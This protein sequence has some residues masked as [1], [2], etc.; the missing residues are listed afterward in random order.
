M[1]PSTTTP[2]T[3]ADINAMDEEAF[4]AALG[5]AFELS[6]WV[7]RAAHGQGPFA[8]RETLHA[9]MMAALEAAARADKLRL[10]RAHP[11]LAGKAAIAGALTAESAREQ[12]GAGLDR[13]TPAQFERFHA[14]NAAYGQR[15]G[16][17]FIICVRLND[18]TSIL[19]AMQARLANDE[20]AEIAEAIAQIGLISR[21]RLF[22]AVA[23]PIPAGGL[24]ALEAA[25][26]RDLVLLDLGG[27]SWVRP[28]EG[29]ID[30][31]IVGGGQSGL[32]CAFGLMREKVRN[33][34]VLD[35]NTAG[36]E[37]PW[38]TYARMLTLRTPKSLT[39]IDFGLPNLTFR[40]WWEA[41]HGEAGWAALDKIPRGAWMAY[42]RWF[43]AVLEIPVRNDAKVTR[44]IP[45]EPGLFE[46]E[47]AAG[48]RLKARKVVLATG[49][50]GGGEWHAP[51]FITKA[52]APSRWAHTS[53]D[54]DFEAL[55]GKRVAILGGGASAFDNAQH[56]LKA[57]VGL[58]HVFVRREA[59]PS[60]N[61]IRFME[62][63][64]FSRHFAQFDDADKYAVIDSFLDRNQPPT[65]DTFTRA[66]AYPGFALHLGSPWLK[67][68]DTAHGVVVTTPKGRF[69]Y[70]F[71][72]LSTGLKT[73]AA[74]RPELAGLAE[75]IVL[76][77]DRHQPNG[78]RNPL[79]D[80]HPYLGPGFEFQAR[81]SQG[82]L[83][84]RGLFAF[85][86]SALASL[87]LSASALSGMKFA[88]PKLT[89]AVTGQLFLDDRDAV[90]DDF[91]AY[92]APEFVS[93]WSP[94]AT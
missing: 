59:L 48:E 42:L 4:T 62:A 61:P 38:A 81:T 41:Q 77:R 90:L 88:L 93:D 72:I 79:I 16:F 75:D 64:G 40:A 9:A 91:Y 49:I 69:D 12:A 66:A 20:D 1:S 73:D 24:P 76:W 67:V 71:L 14:L 6:P 13:L 54:I 86:Y 8:G 37:G 35:E 44:I 17:P 94:E 89:H 70:D 84:L 28:R 19:A 51:T 83:R 43:R 29:V 92:D 3:L 68:E 7:V 26:R 30:V 87:G 31:V 34:L 53:Q 36:L 21:L 25:V 55:R 22:D 46:V 23:E 74:L 47:L 60:V 78:R 10:I 39:A 2:L 45:I 65:N 85:N 57:G 82:A 33:I 5:F 52:L 18:K 11:E 56:G 15:F 32:G 27:P 58:M 63:S 80:A 50:Q